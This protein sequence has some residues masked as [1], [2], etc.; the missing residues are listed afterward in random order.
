M[1][2][3]ESKGCYF[4]FHKVKSVLY[5]VVGTYDS[6]IGQPLSNKA[7]KFVEIKRTG[8]VITFTGV[9]Q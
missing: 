4:L 9:N 1:Y 7:S 5:I 3:P 6:M 8:T 2:F